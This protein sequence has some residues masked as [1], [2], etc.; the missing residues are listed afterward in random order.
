MLSPI[1]HTKASPPVPPQVPPPLYCLC[2]RPLAAKLADKAREKYGKKFWQAVKFGSLKGC[3]VGV[4][5][6]VLKSE[7][8]VLPSVLPNLHNVEI[9][10]S[11]FDAS[12]PGLDLVWVHAL[13]PHTDS[14]ILQPVLLAK[15]TRNASETS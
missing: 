9:P 3:R 13:R 1:F 8:V 15:W 5:L 11:L 14:G 6:C 7:K 10:P 2:P 12:S 4:L